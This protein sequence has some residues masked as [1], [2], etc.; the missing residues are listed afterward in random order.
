MNH[1]AH[2]NTPGMLKARFHERF[3]KVLIDLGIPGRARSDLARLYGNHLIDKEGFTQVES[4]F[5]LNPYREYNL[6][7]LAEEIAQNLEVY[8]V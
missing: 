2:L 4:E 3:T 7:E 5:I 1:L 6:L 8:E